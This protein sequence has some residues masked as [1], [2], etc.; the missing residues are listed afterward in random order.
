MQINVMEEIMLDNRGYQPTPQSPIHSGFG[1]RTTASEALKGHDL[2][3][4]I[5]IVTGGH[6]GSASKPP[7]PSP[8]PELT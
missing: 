5:A 8:K 2:N 7:A 1:P 3:G 6:S 4:T